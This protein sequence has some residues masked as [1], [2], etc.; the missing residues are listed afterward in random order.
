MDP[1]DE[2]VLAKN[3][4]VDAKVVREAQKRLAEL[5]DANVLPSVSYGLAPALGGAPL[6][7]THADTEN[8]SSR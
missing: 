3:P 6:S 1:K 7:Q 4:K 2:A 8:K 5:R